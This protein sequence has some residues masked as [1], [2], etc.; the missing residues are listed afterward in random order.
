MYVGTHIHTHD[1]HHT[2][3][4][5]CTHTPD[6]HDTSMHTHTLTTYIGTNMCTHATHIHTPHAH[7]HMSSAQPSALT[8]IKAQCQLPGSPNGPLHFYNNIF[9]GN[10]GQ[11]CLW[12][13]GAVSFHTKVKSYSPHNS[14]AARVKRGGRAPAPSRRRANCSCLA[15]SPLKPPN[16]PRASLAPQRL[17]LALR[18]CPLSL[19]VSEQQHR[20]A[21][22]PVVHPIQDSEEPFPF[23]KFP[24]VLV[25]GF[26]SGLTARLCS[27]PWS[28][29]PQGEASVPS[30]AGSLAQLVPE[31]TSEGHM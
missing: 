31:H 14:P 5:T 25:V 24:L 27:L 18:N 1:E 30:E 9:N 13:V 23:W 2:S 11:S 6:T 17:P 26:P 4:H 12:G 29:G 10:G 19:S 3:V 21:P 22:S 7:I 16:L 8:A 15:D 28:S 20:P